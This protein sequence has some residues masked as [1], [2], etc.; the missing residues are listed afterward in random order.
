MLVHL[1][2][3]YKMR[4]RDFSI[5][6]LA[7]HLTV[8]HI[9]DVFLHQLH[10]TRPSLSGGKAV[11][12]SN[13]I[14]ASQISHKFPMFHPFSTSIDIPYL[15][16]TGAFIWPTNLDV[17]A[18]KQCRFVIGGRMSLRGA[19]VQ[20]LFRESSAVTEVVPINFDFSARQLVE[21]VPSSTLTPMCYLT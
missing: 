5:Y 18:S 16:Q 14:H 2:S 10:L 7:S 19:D 9:S 8:L 4:S 12:T 1:H 17:Q 20:P 21:L 11:C 6:D 3:T 15:F 13:L